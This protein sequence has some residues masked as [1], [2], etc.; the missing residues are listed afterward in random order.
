MI[1]R[2]GSYVMFVIPDSGDISDMYREFYDSSCNYM[3]VL[4]HGVLFHQIVGIVWKTPYLDQV[5][6][7]MP[8][9]NL[10]FGFGTGNCG[11][12]VKFGDFEQKLVTWQSVRDGRKDGLQVWMKLK[13]IRQLSKNFMNYRKNEMKLK[14]LLGYIFIIII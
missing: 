14:Q 13:N 11:T 3:Q 12:Y 7:G 8:E 10:K 5:L 1:A 6:N 9:A 4:I 2:I